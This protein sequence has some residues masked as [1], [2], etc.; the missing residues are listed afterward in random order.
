MLRKALLFLSLVALL[1]LA[2]D[3]AVRVA[4]HFDSAGFGRG[5]LTRIIGIARG[6]PAEDGAAAAPADRAEPEPGAR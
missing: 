1:V 5:E 2:P 4:D 6:M 3:I